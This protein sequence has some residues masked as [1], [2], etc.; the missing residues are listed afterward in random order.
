MSE[1]PKQQ[2]LVSDAKDRRDFVYLIVTNTGT[3]LESLKRVFQG[4]KDESALLN[5]LKG[6]CSQSLFDDRFYVVNLGWIDSIKTACR[7][8]REDGCRRTG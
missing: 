5:A 1:L 8:L 6:R 2:V 3:F 7:V 4:E